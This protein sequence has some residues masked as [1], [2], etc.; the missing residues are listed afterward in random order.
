MRSEA[1]PKKPPRTHLEILSRISEL[2][3]VAGYDPKKQQLFVHWQDCDPRLS[4]IIS[5]NEFD[6]APRYLR[7]SLIAEARGST[8]RPQSSRTNSLLSGGV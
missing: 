5:Y 8:T 1:Y 4:S 6:R 3:G 7:A 2:T